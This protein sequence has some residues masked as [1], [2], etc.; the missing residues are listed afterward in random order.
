MK[1]LLKNL[2]ALSFGLL[3]SLI[4]L[5]IACAVLVQLDRIPARKPPYTMKNTTQPFWSDLNPHFGVWHF[6]NRSFR[7]I[8][9][10]FD[11]EYTSNSYGAR[12][13]E[14]QQT[15]TGNRIAVVGDSFIEGWG[16]KREDRL[17][18]VLEQKTEIEFLNFGTSGQFGP[19]QE[20]LLYKHLAKSFDHTAVI[21]GILPDN[22]FEDDYRNPSTRF[23][24]YWEGEY[25]DYELKYTIESVEQSTFFLQRPKKFFK[26]VL[27]NYTYLRNIYDYIGAVYEARSRE[28]KVASGG[29]SND[30][31]Y[32][33]YAEAQFNRMRY[34]YEQIIQEA[35]GKPILFFA[36]PRLKDLQWYD[37]EQTSPLG[38]ALSNWAGQYPN[39]QFIDFLPLFHERVPKENRMGYYI[40]CDG[41]W[42]DKGQQ[43]AAELIM[44][45]GFLDSLYQSK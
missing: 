28:E 29:F 26:H 37:Q 27:L 39:T 7:H 19:T 41:H 21:V 5:E 14:R 3:L 24:P 15:Y 34:S 31:Y 35:E 11:L 8:R 9:N 45:T 38:D 40:E 17:T 16:V 23:F 44:E 42:T 33:N 6:N 10:C 4:V 2:L 20:Y 12:D 32:V 43:L 1:K 22:D 13:K 30:S 25:P 36:I 18:D